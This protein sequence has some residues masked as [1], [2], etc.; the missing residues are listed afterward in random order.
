MVQALSRLRLRRLS[1]IAE[2][3]SGLCMR[4]GIHHKGSGVRKIGRLL[5]IAWRLFCCN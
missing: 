2:V 3:S 4:S 1:V 5:S